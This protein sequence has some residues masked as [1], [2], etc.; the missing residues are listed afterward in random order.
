MTTKVQAPTSHTTPCSTSHHLQA[1]GS[2]RTPKWINDALNLF[3]K[4]SWRDMHEQVS[5]AEERTE[6]TVKFVNHVGRF[7]CT[8]LHPLRP[9]PTSNTL[10]TL[11]WIRHLGHIKL[12][13]FGTQVVG[14]RTCQW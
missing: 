8:F 3:G 2:M 6:D 4:L 5:E 9:T 7:L 1:Q 12:Q 10:L 14:T 11:L 13:R